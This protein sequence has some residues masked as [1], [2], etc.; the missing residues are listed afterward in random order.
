M[1][2]NSIILYISI[3]AIPLVLAITLH[4]AA[5]ALAAS[6]LGDQTARMLG[7][8]SLNPA[9]HID[10][11]GT[12]LFPALTIAIGSMIPGGRFLIFGWAKPVPVNFNQL[13]HRRMGTVL[14]AFA[15]PFAN[16]LMACAWAAVCKL[17]IMFG[18]SSD[19]STTGVITKF[20]FLSSQYGVYIN[21]ILFVLNLL[22]LP[23]LDGGRI[24]TALL[25]ASIARPLELI[26]PY[27]IWILLALIMLGVLGSI[28]MP[29]VHMLI[30]HF[31]AMFYI[32]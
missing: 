11:V 29:I 27:G 16:L 20:L 9:K 17:V 21:A 14:V 19:Q 18:A 28:I 26:E 13:N 8:V 1:D 12:I 15:G 24:L 5:H 31:Y 30:G 23:P 3:A 4:E 6:K 25:P 2:F 10:P 22:P 32:S 7:R